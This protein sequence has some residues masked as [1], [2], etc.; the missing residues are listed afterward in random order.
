[1]VVGIVQDQD[2]HRLQE[3]DQHIVVDLE[4]LVISGI[5]ILEIGVAVVVL[6]EED[7][8]EVLTP[9]TDSLVHPIAR[10]IKIQY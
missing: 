9:V 10:N 1:M 6:A 2:I 4:I 7:M 8:I 3:A 5:M